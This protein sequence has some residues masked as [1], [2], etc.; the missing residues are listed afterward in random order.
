MS[1]ADTRVG[2]LDKSVAVL[3]AVAAGARSIGD[4][5][6]ATSLSRATAH[7]L[8]AALEA[9]GLLTRGGGRGLRL[10]PRLMALASA[11]GDG[12]SLPEIAGPYVERL[13][14]ST[15]ESA[16]LYV[17]RGDARVCIEVAEST[18]ELRTIVERG[19]E[20]PLTAG[21]AGKV[22]LAWADERDRDRLIA[23]VPRL[24]PATPTRPEEIRAELA[25]VRERG[26]AQ[27]VGEREPGVA[28][29]S[30]PVLGERGRLLAVVSVSGPVERTSKWPVRRYAKEVTAA[31]RDIERALD[32]G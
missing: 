5:V 11:A 25:A 24:T 13:Q 6:A 29:V 21:S 31:A 3:E 27:S 4:V 32:A 9:H 23:H 10:G 22:F 18:R 12:G 26:W 16:Q 19:A 20:L 14:A 17:R 1:V 30:A 28:S 8:I 2:V 15:G 7:R